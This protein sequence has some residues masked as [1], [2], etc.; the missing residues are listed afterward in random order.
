MRNKKQSSSVRVNM[1]KT[2]KICYISPKHPACTFSKNLVENGCWFINHAS[3]RPSTHALAQTFVSPCERI[4]ACSSE[5]D[6]SRVLKHDG[7]YRMWPFTSR[8]HPFHSN[9]QEF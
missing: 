4:L 6:D 9:T 2:F 3:V 7:R 8:G 1:A 5:K